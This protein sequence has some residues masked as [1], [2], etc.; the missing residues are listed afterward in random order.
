MFL[1]LF[2]SLLGFI[3]SNVFNSCFLGAIYFNTPLWCLS[4]IFYITYFICERLCSDLLSVNRTRDFT[5]WF[6]RASWIKTATAK[7]LFKM[8]K[9]YASAKFHVQYKFV[10]YKLIFNIFTG[11]SANAVPHYQKLCSRDSHIWGIRRGQHS[12]S[13]MAE[14][15]PGWTTFVIMVS[16]LPGK[17]ELY[18]AQSRNSF[19]VPQSWLR[20]TKKNGTFNY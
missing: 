20:G 16:P 6:G 5:D 8:F 7:C 11:E 15:R 9:Q 17:Y 10:Q 3:F 19:T 13:A 2:V 12:R 1:S 4:L 14:P 18:I